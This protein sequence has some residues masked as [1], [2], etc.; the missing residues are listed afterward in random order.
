MSLLELCAEGAAFLPEHQRDCPY[1]RTEEWT[2]N[3]TP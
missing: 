2:L 3:G 1:R